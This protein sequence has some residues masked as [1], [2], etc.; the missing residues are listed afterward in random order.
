MLRRHQWAVEEG[1]AVEEVCLRYHPEAARHDHHHLADL[2]C[3]R[4]NQT[5]GR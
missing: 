5:G 1:A 2:S 3:L 4:L